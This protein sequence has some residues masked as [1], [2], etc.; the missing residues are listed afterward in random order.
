MSKRF[1]VPQHEIDEIR[2]IRNR[3]RAIAGKLSNILNRYPNASESCPLYM[4][5]N[6]AKT[7]R[8][9]FNELDEFSSR[10]IISEETPGDRAEGFML[11]ALQRKILC[12]S[13]KFSNLEDLQGRKTALYKTY[14]EL[15]Q[16]GLI[17]I[18]QCI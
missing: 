16:S 15:V 14:E 3:R 9:I 2:S 18:E 10:P 5:E 6:Y 4:N 8:S 11:Y 7:M 1:D 12:A 17:K 13:K